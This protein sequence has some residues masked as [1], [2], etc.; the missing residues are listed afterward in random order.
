MES[1]GAVARQCSRS[2]LARGFASL[3]LRPAVHRG[4][5]FV[6]TFGEQQVLGAMIA[7]ALFSAARY[8]IMTAVCDE[9]DVRTVAVFQVAEW[10]W[11]SNWDG[12]GSRGRSVCGNGF[13]CLQC[14]Q[15][16]RCGHRR[17]LQSSHSRAFRT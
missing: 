2:H 7:K 6:T 8:E 13:C 1:A 12:G 9:K 11:V 16:L 5:W 4:D 14:R 3:P 15:T 10:I 17:L